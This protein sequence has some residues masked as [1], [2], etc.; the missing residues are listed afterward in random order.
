MATV[1]RSQLVTLLY[2]YK[3]SGAEDEP[4]GFTD[5]PEKAY[6]AGAVAWAA[7]NGITYGI[8]STHY[9]PARSCTRAQVVAF[10]WRLEGTEVP[11][12]IS[13]TPFVDV[14]ENAYYY[15]ALLCAYDD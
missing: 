1:T 14:S 8:G 4:S 7:K 11:A 9:A 2:R 10:L 13:Q 6:Y 15:P 5:E 12:G 3:G